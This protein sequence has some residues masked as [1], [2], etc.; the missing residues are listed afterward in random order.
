MT[1]KELAGPGARKKER[2]K[3]VPEEC[4]CKCHDVGKKT[5]IAEGCAIG[6]IRTALGSLYKS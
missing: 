5:L 2:K 4:K 6:V 3:S 1:K